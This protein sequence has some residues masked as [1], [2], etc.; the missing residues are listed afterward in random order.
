ML[1]RVGWSQM[2]SR[3]YPLIVLILVL[4]A[5]GQAATKVEPRPS[6]TGSDPLA[7]R[8]EVELVSEGYGYTEGPQW[9]PKDAV[10]RLGIVIRQ[11]RRRSA[12][13]R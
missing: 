8:G 3:I 2:R 10:L 9:M 6:S 12:H 1:A 11:P 13:T 7:G 4:S 5:C